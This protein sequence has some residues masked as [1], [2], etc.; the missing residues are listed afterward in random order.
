MPIWAGRREGL[1]PNGLPALKRTF[2]LFSICLVLS[3][4]TA[5]AWTC[6]PRIDPY[7]SLIVTDAALDRSKFALRETLGAILASMKDVKN[8]EEN[9]EKFLKTLLD[10]LKDEHRENSVSGLPVQVYKRPFEANLDPKVLLNPAEDNPF[11]LV[12]VALVNRIDLAPKEWSNCG[13]YRIIYTFRMRNPKNKV[14]PTGRFF[15]IFEA[16]VKNQQ[17][18]TKF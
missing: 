8:D 3:N 11:A 15:L 6:A 10:S 4:A 7:R 16:V 17:P 14:G 18:K 2:A 5:H 13:E 9:R 12:P 1:M